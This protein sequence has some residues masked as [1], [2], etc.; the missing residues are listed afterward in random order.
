[1]AEYQQVNGKRVKL[2]AEAEADVL[3]FHAENQ[4]AQIAE[5]REAKKNVLIEYEKNQALELQIAGKRTAIESMDDAALDAA[6]AAA[7][8]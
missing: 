7:G 6:I 4:A 2:S 8:L 5:E 1:M 3:A